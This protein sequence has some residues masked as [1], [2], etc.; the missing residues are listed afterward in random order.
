VSAAAFTLRDY[1]VLADGQRGALVD[2]HGGIAFLCFPRWHDPA[3]LSSLLGG[4]GAY[5]VTPRERFVWGGH[6]EDPGLVWRSRWIVGD[7]VI[8]CRES[9]ARPARADRL[10]LLRRV[11]AVRGP[12]RVRVRLDLRADWDREPPHDLSCGEDGAWRGRLADAPMAWHGAGAARRSGAGA[13]EIELDVS[14]GAHHDLVLVLGDDGPI[15]P[16][17]QLWEQ[18][19][20]AWRDDVP[21]LEDTVAPRDARLACAVLQGLTTPGRGMV[22]AVTTALPERAEAGRDFDYRFVW[23]RDQCYAGQAAARAGVPALL[24]E[25][26]T[27]VRERLLE[28][29]DQLAPATTIG[30][31]PVPRTSHMGLPGYPGGNDQIG[32]Q[33][34]DQFQLDAFGESLSLFAAAAR[35]DRLTAEDHRAA[36]LAAEAVARRWR[37]PGAGVWEIELRHWTHSRLSCVAGL[38]AM[39]EHSAEGPA[40]RWRELAGV[41]MG[42]LEATSLTRDGRWRRAPDD[43][44]L[45][46]ALLNGAIRGAVAPEDPRSVATR[47]AVGEALGREG[48]V[49]RFEHDAPLGETEG[50]FLLCGFWMAQA[51]ALE[52]RHTEAVRWFERGRSACGSPG[53]LS[54]EL[55][56]EQRQ[57]RGNLPQAFVHAA[58]L[59]SAAALAP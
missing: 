25:A 58:L 24:D 30:G 19:E 9:L 42:E 6:Y 39:A 23:I 43:D 2:P 41:L 37:E 40:A 32:N 59:E 47:R 48:Y 57:L 3:V 34:R 55:D 20:A 38:R 33:V 28:S 56:V 16:A 49:Y 36:A 21:A 44:R 54:E 13:L 31:D 22:A 10:I 8:E 12:A 5:S 26:V 27:A 1:A 18:T 52:G 7:C 45:D 14:E 11:L 17:D 46:A 29:G 50:A 51:S 4:Q 15:A 53:L 35:L